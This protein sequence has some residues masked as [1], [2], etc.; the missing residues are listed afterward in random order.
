MVAM[1]NMAPCCV[2]TV[3]STLS[4]LCS[5]LFVCVYS[6][7]TLTSFSPPVV[8]YVSYF[9]SFAQFFCLP[10][11]RLLHLSFTPQWPP[12]R[13][14]IGLNA[15]QN[16]TTFSASWQPT[17]TTTRQNTMTQN[18]DVHMHR[19]VKSAPFI[20]N[21]VNILHDVYA[22]VTSKCIPHNEVSLYHCKHTVDV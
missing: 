2:L 5:P 19:N 6:S 20:I 18:P 3:A 15:V 9:S 22:G 21:D 4:P 8:L 10:C 1:V 14:Q 13:L 17:G 16:N 12:Y 11:F 7:T